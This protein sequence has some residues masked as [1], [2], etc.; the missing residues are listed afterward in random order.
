M[1]PARRRT[2]RCH[3][4]F[5]EI[6]RNVCL[7][8][9]KQRV[10]PSVLRASIVGSPLAHLRQGRHPFKGALSSHVRFDELEKSFVEAPYNPPL[11]PLDWLPS[12]GR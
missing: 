9:C 2:P 7:V 11:V 8:S 3:G 1:G 10:A 6:T 12:R 4:L 5:D